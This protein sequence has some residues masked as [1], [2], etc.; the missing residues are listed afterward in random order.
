MDQFKC[1]PRSTPTHQGIVREVTFAILNHIRQHKKSGH[2]FF[3]PCD[4]FLDEHLNAV[5]PD[6]IFISAEQESIIK[7]EAIH[8]C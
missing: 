7:D 2:I 6:I 3:A 1:Q 4:V 8:G 5:Q